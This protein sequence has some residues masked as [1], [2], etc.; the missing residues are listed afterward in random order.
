MIGVTYFTRVTMPIGRTYHVCEDDLFAALARPR[1][2]QSKMELPGI[3]LGTYRGGRRALANLI[4]AYGCAGDVDGG[5]PALE[6]VL[7]ALAGL[8]GYVHSTPSSKPHDRR[9][10]PVILYREPVTDPADARR[11]IRWLQRRL[12]GKV[13]FGT[14]DPSRYWFLPWA[15]A[16]HWQHA[17]LDGEPL[18]ALRIAREERERE[19]HEAAERRARQFTPPPPT[20]GGYAA[21]ALRR[22]CANVAASV[23]PNRHKTLAREAWSMGQLVGAGLLSRSDALAALDHA[24]RGIFPENREH[25]RTRTIAQQVDVGAHSPREIRRSPWG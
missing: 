9:W 7:A 11:V 20:T 13:D 3:S 8:Y 17:M 6:D 4:A 14:C 24:S 22:A 10:R 25:E 23:E 5:N 12:P 2:A 15:G 19:E 21:G 16:E 1:R 18:D